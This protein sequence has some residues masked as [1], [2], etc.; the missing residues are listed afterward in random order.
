MI[1]V[2][3]YLFS[4][5]CCLNVDA[6]SYAVFVFITSIISFDS[7]LPSPCRSIPSTDKGKP[8]IWMM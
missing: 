6:E 4:F 5:L 2:Y 8:L 3:I 1:S 7:A